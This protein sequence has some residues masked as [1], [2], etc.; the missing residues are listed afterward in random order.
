MDHRLTWRPGEDGEPAVLRCYQGERVAL[1]VY[2]LSCRQVPG[3][4]IL[5]RRNDDGPI[6][7]DGFGRDHLLNRWMP[8]RPSDLHTECKQF[9][10]GVYDGGA[11]DGGKTGNRINCRT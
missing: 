5:C 11:V 9:I 7:D 2:E 8:F 6:S 10:L 1:I 4:A 3:A